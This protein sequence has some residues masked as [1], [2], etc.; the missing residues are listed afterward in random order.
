[1]FQVRM[2][3]YAKEQATYVFGKT[4]RA[5]SVPPLAPVWTPKKYQHAGSSYTLALKTRELPSS[6]TAQQEDT[7]ADEHRA[8]LQDYFRASLRNKRCPQKGKMSEE[9]KHE[10]SMRKQAQLQHLHEQREVCL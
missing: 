9:A 7:Q 5:S 8:R 6:S 3:E 1:M 2:Q 10:L 4:R